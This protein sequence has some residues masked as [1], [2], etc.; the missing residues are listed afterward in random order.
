[1]GGRFLDELGEIGVMRF[2]DGVEERG[3][4]MTGN[5]EIKI[6]E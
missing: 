1:M 3:G 6:I 4:R 5:H 2:L